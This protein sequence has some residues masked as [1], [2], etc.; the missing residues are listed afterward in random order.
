MLISIETSITWGG[1]GGGGGV[2]FP[3]ILVQAMNTY[4]TE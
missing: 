3:L 4:L 2:A 1:G